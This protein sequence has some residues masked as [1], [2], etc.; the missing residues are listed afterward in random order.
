MTAAKR[1][2]RKVRT[3]FV[4]ECAERLVECAASPGECAAN[5]I[6]GACG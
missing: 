3:V 2:R 5:L 1:R 6:V 4:S